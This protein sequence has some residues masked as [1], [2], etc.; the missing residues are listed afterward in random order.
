MI[1]EEK[2]YI[3]IR[4]LKSYYFSKEI[5]WKCDKF[6]YILIFLYHVKVC[7]CKKKYY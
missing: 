1:L 7:Y 5:Q 3:R 4:Q 6:D 2:H